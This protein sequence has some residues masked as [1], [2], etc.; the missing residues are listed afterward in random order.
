[1][2]IAIFTELYFP[3][4]GG[5]EMFFHGLAKALV[6][7]GH[8]LDVYCIGHENGLAATE[9]IDGVNVHRALTVA[10]YKIPLFPAMKRKWRGIL[11]FAWRVRT[12]ARRAEHD[13]YLLN[14]WPFLHALLLPLRARQ[15]A[16]L[17]WCEI[18]RSR[19]YL[20]CQKHLPRRVVLNAAISESVAAE[21]RDMSGQKVFPLPSGLDLTRGV[22]KPRSERRDIV[23]LGRVT[24]HK[25]LGLLITAFE[26]MKA[27]GYAGRL[28]VAGDGP[29]MPAVVQ[30]VAA[31][32]CRNDI[33]LL[34][35]I[36]D[37]LKFHLLS[38]CEMLA[39]PSKREGFPHVV[40]EAMCCGLPIVTAD[41]PENGTKTVVEAYGVGV[42][43]APNAES[44]AAGMRCVLVEWERFSAR[45][46]KG[47]AQLDWN[48]IA[49]VLESNLLEVLEPGLNIS[50]G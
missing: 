33:D 16:L 46:L 25:N 4:V 36:A 8:E 35:F 42:V 5:Q 34:G 2:R 43:T 27:G 24:A 9:V 11:G 49:S 23:V 10:E 28:K 6:R 39:M 41:Y 50:P 22:S 48:A 40:A 26:M 37:E 20:A 14:Q 38:G 19:F 31:S 21:I 45:G 3:S 12:I 29:D 17:H 7:R 32:A 13:I 30:R 47:S 44:F 18:R 1:M 15:R